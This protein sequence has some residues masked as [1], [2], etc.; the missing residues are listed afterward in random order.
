MKKNIKTKQFRHD[1]KTASDI[2]EKHNLKL[3]SDFVNSK[4]KIK[5]KC[6]CGNIFNVYLNKLKRGHTKS[7]GC[8]ALYKI[9]QKMI[10]KK[11]GD[12][13]VLE[14]IKTDKHRAAVWKVKCDC[15][16]IKELSSSRLTSGNDTGCGNCKRMINGVRASREQLMI[17]NMLDKGI[18]NYRYGKYCIDV[19]LVWNNKK[20]AIEYDEFYWHKN[21]CNK[22]RDEF[23]SNNNW[24]VIHINTR[25]K[26]PIK[27]I[28]L[29][30]L[31]N[32]ND[33]KI[34]NIN[35]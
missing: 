12:L 18:I 32:L 13:L 9:K 2:C 10:G 33:E 28:I 16:K 31:N 34:I 30:A 17:K 7:C 4:T 14:F 15:G 27:E 22:T 29:E 24:Y 6:F 21:K 11:F 26:P 1:Q 3:L 19:A 5:V 35:L 25:R 20:V 8:L 23:L